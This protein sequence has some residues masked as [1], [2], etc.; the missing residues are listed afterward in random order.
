MEAQPDEI[1]V[2]A[3]RPRALYPD[4]CSWT[5]SSP[6]PG[7]LPKGEGERFGSR[8]QSHHPRNSEIGGRGLPLPEGEGWGEGERDAATA[9]IGIKRGSP[10]FIPALN[11]PVC[12]SY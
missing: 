3:G 5:R 6:H 8:K 12:R 10:R 2:L 4:P 7:P 11:I 1:K 9:W